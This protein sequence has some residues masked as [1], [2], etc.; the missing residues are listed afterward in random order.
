M[1]LDSEALDEDHERDS[2]PRR[3][4][5]ADLFSMHRYRQFQVRVFEH[6]H[7]EI[8]AEGFDDADDVY[9]PIISLSEEL[10]ITTPYQPSHVVDSAVSAQSPPAHS[11]AASDPF[12]NIAS[13]ASAPVFS[14]APASEGVLAD[15]AAPAKPKRN[16]THATVVGLALLGAVVAAAIFSP[17]LFTVLVYGF[18]V[19]GAIEWRRALRRQGRHIPL[20]PIVA[21]IVG[22]GI[23]TWNAKPEGLVVALLVGCAGVIA[24]R[25][26]D[27]RVENTLADSMA[28]T[29]TLMWL[30]F[31]ASFLVLLELAQDG[32]MRVVIV[33]VAV[34]GNDTG[35][36]LFGS[37]F[38][39]H[40][41][42]PRVSPGKTWEGFAGGVG[43]GVAAASIAAFFFWDGR[44]WI[45]ALV[46]LAATLAAVMGD[47]AESAIKRDLEVKDMSGLLPGHGGIL[48]RMDSLV[49]AA[50]V[51]Y[52]AFAFFLGTLG[53][54]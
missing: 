10:P 28:A 18:C 37:L 20:V 39:K 52:V 21:A 33:L 25:L 17:L 47:L 5:A 12:F 45:G 29:L 53:S 31:L 19:V 32:W 30:P 4:R 27:E 2:V 40:K 50:P 8:P 24:W 35:G 36:L 22:M 14:S 34:S 43:L 44:W 42:L 46:G 23:A 3:S 9:D 6:R 16:I 38:G 11:P 7:A 15:V 48:D 41:M 54:L 1:H 13:D 51:A 26:S 49:F